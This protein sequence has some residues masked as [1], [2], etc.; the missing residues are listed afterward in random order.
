MKGNPILV[1]ISILIIVLPS[2]Q[3]CIVPAFSEIQSARTVGTSNIEVTPSYTSVSANE[4]GESDG[5]QNHAGLRF[6]LGLTDQVDLRAK[7]ERIWLKDCE[8]CEGV[9]IAGMGPKFSLVEDQVAFYLPVGRAF[10]DD[11]DETWQLHPTLLLTQNIKDQIDVTFAPKYLITFCEDCDD[12][13]ALNFGLGLSDDFDKWAF[14]AE[15][16]ILH[17]LK[18]DTPGHYGQFSLGLSWIFSGQSKANNPSG[19]LH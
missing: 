2:M 17:N 18:E 8:D 15:Y 1:Y 19:M 6:A 4:E 11:T 16:G 14:R 9:S 10:G 5:I 12:L 7:Y 13:L 3:S